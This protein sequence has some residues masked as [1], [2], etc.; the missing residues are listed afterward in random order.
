MLYTRRDPPSDKRNAKSKDRDY[1]SLSTLWSEM[2]LFSIFARIGCPPWHLK[3]V[4]SFYVDMKGIVQLD[5]PSELRD[6]SC[7]F[8]LAIFSV[9]FTVLLRQTFRTSIGVYIP[10]RSGGRLQSVPIKDKIQIHKVLIRDIIFAD[11]VTLGK[12]F[13]AHISTLYTTFQEPVRISIWPS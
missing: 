12:K 2:C 1:V 4:Q 7:V 6:Q 5:V 8:A 3:I 13:E 10:T 9:F 11:N